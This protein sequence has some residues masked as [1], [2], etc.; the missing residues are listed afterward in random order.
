MSISLRQ[1]KRRAAAR[2]V[3]R[4][5]LVRAVAARHFGGATFPTHLSASAGFQVVSYQHPRARGGRKVRWQYVPALH[6]NERLI[7]RLP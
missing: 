7:P 2:M 3:A 4:V 6:V 1:H 5:N